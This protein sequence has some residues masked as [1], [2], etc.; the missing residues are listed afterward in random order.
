MQN[1]GFAT[2]IARQF[3]AA[4][5]ILLGDGADRPELEDFAA[6]FARSE[7]LDAAAV[8][9]ELDALLPLGGT[10]AC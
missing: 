9:A 3:R 1:Q 10:L 8:A 5:A 2:P 4:V 6:W 7:D